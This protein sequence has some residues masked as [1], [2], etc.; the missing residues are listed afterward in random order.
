[1]TVF[2]KYLSIQFKMDLRD[3]GTLMNFYVVPIVF[4]F[5]IGGVF[6]SINP[7]MK[8]TLAATMTIFA[9]T[10]GAIMGTPT[11]VV[12]LRESGTIRAFRVN[13]ISGTS[14]LF[15]RAVSAF[16]HLF[17]VS[18]VIYFSS[19]VVFHSEIPVSP[20]SYFGVLTV[21]LIASVWAGLFIGVVSRDQSFATM[22]SMIVFLPSILFSGIMF[23]VSMLP[24]AL[25]GLGYI[26]PATY[27]LASIR[28]FAYGIQMNSGF[29][30][31]PIVLAGMAALM[32]FL[33]NW[34]FKSVKRG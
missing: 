5:V 13:G 22:F 11:P 1:M 26:F 25:S 33:T 9:M 17:I 2:L 16:A 21:F 6:S 19:P 23:P 15:A 28:G 30:I 18:L 20:L 24:K 14:V 8:M 3:R 12:K 32:F 4:F 10:M 29:T 27:A 31:Y 34:R 7:T